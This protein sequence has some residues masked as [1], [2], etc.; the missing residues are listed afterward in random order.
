MFSLLYYLY[1]ILAIACP[2]AC[3][4]M[5]VLIARKR[6]LSGFLGVWAIATGTAMLSGPVNMISALYMTIESFARFS[7]V[8]NVAVTLLTMAAYIVIL[9]YVYMKYEFKWMIPI[10]V[11]SVI[12]GPVLTTVLS[13]TMK[14]SASDAIS[15]ARYAYFICLIGTLPVIIV[16]IILFYVFI[17]NRA[18]EKYL[19]AVFLVPVTSLVGAVIEAAV[20]IK[21]LMN[22]ASGANSVIGGRLLQVILLLTVTI[23]ILSKDPQERKA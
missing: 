7:S 16:W 22:P 10:L 6:T 2:L 14:S 12:S 23:Y 17:R 13:V 5:G 4:V 9:C 19:K 18:K 15:I 1:I 3:I 21:N 11:F 20:Y 8:V